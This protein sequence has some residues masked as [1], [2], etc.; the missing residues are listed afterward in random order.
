MLNKTY[1]VVSDKFHNFATRKDVITKSELY[2][3]LASK[4][5][6]FTEPN[7]VRLIPGQG[8]S[9][10]DN[11]NILHLAK[12]SANAIH[13]DFSLWHSIP[14]RASKELTH[15]HMNENILVSE[16]KRLSESEF[17]MNVLIDENCEMMRDHQTGLHVQGML[18]LEASRQ[19]YLSIFEKFLSNNNKEKKY[20]IFNNLNVDYNRFAFP[21][22]AKLIVSIRE[23]DLSNS[24][25]QHVVMDMQM[26]Q[27]GSTSASFALDMTVMA[28]KRIS[29]METKMANQT[30]DNHI[31]HLFNDS[32]FNEVANA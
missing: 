32:N 11:R 30:L 9:E 18:L 13:F 12:T 23:I 20:F 5:I 1:L 26:I 3:L 28:D 2:S 10:V 31:N 6:A 29:I 27:C 7:K 22:P 24:K 17:S 21:L 4:N 25:K 14:T 15:K 16:P 19:G 8:F